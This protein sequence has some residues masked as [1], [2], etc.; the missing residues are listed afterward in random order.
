MGLEATL[1]REA[2]GELCDRL[3]HGEGVR[4]FRKLLGEEV[5]RPM[6]HSHLPRWSYSLPMINKRLDGAYYNFYCIASVSSISQWTF[7]EMM[8]TGCSVCFIGVE[9]KF[10]QDNGYKRTK[11]IGTTGAWMI[12]FDFQDRSNIE[13]DLQDFIS[14]PSSSPGCA[15]FPRRPPFR[16]PRRTAQP[17]SGRAVFSRRRPH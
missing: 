12:G 2:L 17:S 10:A 3:C 16:K 4:F 1:A 9:S 8:L 7:E 14:L 15:P 6:F 11:G 5:N 13:E